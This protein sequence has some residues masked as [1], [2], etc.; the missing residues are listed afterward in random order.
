V[1]PP[2]SKH[3][4]PRTYKKGHPYDPGVLAVLLRGVR[5]QCPRCG[6]D[7]LYQ[8]WNVLKNHCEACDY[9]FEDREGDCWFF[10]YS[11]TAALTGLFIITILLWRPHS[12]LLGRLILGAAS[13]GVIALTLPLRKGIALALDYL[14]EIKGSNILLY[15]VPNQKDDSE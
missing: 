10:L 14:S 2:N 1:R 3:R 4:E 7:S 13:I 12:I 8:Q 6:K 9:G 5:M 11:T 15:D